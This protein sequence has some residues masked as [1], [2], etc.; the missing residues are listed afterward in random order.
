MIEQV[1]INY[2]TKV[3]KKTLF[4]AYIFLIPFVSF[5]QMRPLSWNHFKNEVYFGSGATN[6]LGDLGGG[7]HSGKHFLGDININGT[8]AVFSGGGKTKISEFLTLRLDLAYGYASGADSLTKND[9]RK[10]RNLSFRTT[11]VNLSPLVEY[12]ILP[13][14]FNKRSSP[15]AAYVASGITF[16]YFNPQAKYDGAWY[17]LQ[18]LGTEG[19]LIEEGSS[20]YSKFTVGIPLV[21]G[22]KVRLP[23]GRG[24][25]K[26]SIS[27]GFEATSIWLMTDYF[28]DVST[29]YA[30]TEDIRKT[31]GDIGVKLAD[32]RLVG[33]GSEGE[34]RGN[35]KDKDW[36]GFLQ[37]TVAKKLYNKPKRK[38]NKRT[39][40]S[41]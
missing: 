4:I 31:S 29:V 33:A 6:Y 27:V 15:F 24:G 17:N 34:I 25:K 39:R 9:G 16:M 32:K 23:G 10:S 5:S 14:R 38:N 13:E 36:I 21:L 40:S 20:S 35:P 2:N 41:F 1:S 11:F 8:H 30:N 7:I 22:F 28:D 12:Y 18:E 19:Q 3:L 26:G 37:L